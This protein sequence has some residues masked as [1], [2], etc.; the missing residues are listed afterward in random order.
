MVIYKNQN[1]L[2]GDLRLTNRKII[3]ILGRV[4]LV[5]G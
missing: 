1:L 5:A 2:S 3:A 4:T